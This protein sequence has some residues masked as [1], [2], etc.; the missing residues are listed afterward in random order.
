MSYSGQKCFEKS[1]HVIK[2][3]CTR[4]PS[5]LGD[6]AADV[7]VKAPAREVAKLSKISLGVR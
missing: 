2:G 6:S 4:N 5:E 3:T 7:Y 1:D